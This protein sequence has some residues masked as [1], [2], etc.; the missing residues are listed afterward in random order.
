MDEAGVKTG[1]ATLV[2]I[3]A[4]YA[5]VRL[6]EVATGMPRTS[7][8]AAEVLTALAFALVDGA[9]H[10]GWRGILVFASIC[11]VIGNIVENLGIATGFPFGRYEFL[12]L[13]GPALFRVPMLLGLAYIGMAYVSWTLARTILGQAGARGIALPVLASFIMTAWDW[14][15]DP[16]W[17]TLLHGWSWRDGGPWFGV[18]LSNYCGWFFTDLVIYLAFAVY[19][20]R[21]PAKAISDGRAA[22]WPALVFYAMCAAGNALQVFTRWPQHTAIDATGKIWRVADI[23]AASAMV[24]VFI[25]GGFVL[26]GARRLKTM[27]ASS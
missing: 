13:M 25:M 12:H 4:V 18:P 5:S 3:L 27:P 17:S 7:I 23:L 20:H 9:R 8:V 10:Y 24:S 21:R 2:L 11:A 19:L 14:A 22:A 15:Q 1:T 6:V 26:A 16:V